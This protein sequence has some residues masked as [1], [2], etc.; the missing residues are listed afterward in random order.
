VRETRRIRGV[1]VITGAEYLQAYRYPDSVSRGAHPIDIHGNRSGD[2]DLRFLEEPAYVPYRALIAGGFSNLIV[3]SRCLSADREA[4]ASLRVQASVMGIGQA[5]GTA[6]AL[7]D[8]DLHRMDVDML[9]KR[10][11]ELGAVI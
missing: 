9:Q 11:R 10:L 3:A 5:A 4:F 7:S 1:H 8:G 6:A 2:Q